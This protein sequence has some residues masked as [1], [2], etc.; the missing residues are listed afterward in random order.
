MRDYLSQLARRVQQPEFAV[1]PRPV[2]QFE[3]PQHSI[4]VA[5]E[6]PAPGEADE[7]GSQSVVFMPTETSAGKLTPQADSRNCNES[8]TMDS[9][10][11]ARPAKKSHKSY[12]GQSTAEPPIVRSASR[13]KTTYQPLPEVVHPALSRRPAEQSERIARSAVA[14]VQPPVRIDRSKE[15]TDIASP[16]PS[17]RREF[18]ELTEAVARREREWIRPLVRIENPEGKKASP[19][20]AQATYHG[21]RGINSEPSET[22]PLFGRKADVMPK[23]GFAPVPER[24]IFKLLAAPIAP[25]FVADRVADA[26]TI[27]VTIGRVEIRA[28]VAPTPPTRKISTQS[29]VMSLDEYLRQRNGGRG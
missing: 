17:G 24:G 7:L 4:F 21:E 9:L 15:Q 3:S 2:S 23:S 13:T 29:P 26:P 16:G 12:P 19:L 27:Q 18:S 8:G 11:E 28:T 6:L 25:Q 14:Q 5:P 1:Q 10:S 20:S 22:E